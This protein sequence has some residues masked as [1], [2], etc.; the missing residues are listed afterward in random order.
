ME[1]LTQKVVVDEIP[2]EILEETPP[3]VDLEKLP[4]DETP[5]EKPGRGR[6]PKNPDNVG[7]PRIK[8]SGGRKSKKDETPKMEKT[9]EFFAAQ[10]LGIHQVLTI[11]TGMDLTIKPDDAASL[12]SAIYEVVKEHDLEW[13][14]KFSPYIN[15]ALT[16]VVVETPIILKVKAAVNAKKNQSRET[17]VLKQDIPKVD[18]G[19]PLRQAGA[20]VG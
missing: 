11:F 2:P 19:D 13:L 4:A 6:P 12:G 16:V 3:I 10:V 9:A 7:I 1:V 15:L 8:N 17:K 14:T 5:T 18:T 20:L